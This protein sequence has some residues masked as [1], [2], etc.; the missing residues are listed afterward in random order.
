MLKKLTIILGL[1]IF[2]S[3]SVLADELDDA[4]DIWNTTNN[5]E[6]NFSGQKMITDEQFDKTLENIKQ[7]DRNKKRKKWWQ[8]KAPEINPLCPI[9]ETAE[10]FQSTELDTVVKKMEY[11]PTIM[12]PVRVETSNGEILNPGFYKMTH[13]KI[14]NYDYIIL[15]Q[16]AKYTY[17]L[18]ATHTN[19][20]YKQTELNF[21]QA[22]TTNDNRI[23]FIFGNVDINVESYANIT[24]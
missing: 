19:E 2:I 6:D 21:G 24:N 13:E 12:L 16:D 15:S 17:R 22:I 5:K 20:D 10:M 11:F 14:N 18:P 4:M 9:P 23:K 7:N 8:R 1:L 3:A